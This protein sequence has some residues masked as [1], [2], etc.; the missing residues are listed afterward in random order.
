M[1]LETDTAADEAILYSCP[2][3]HEDIAVESHL[4]GET[5]RCPKCSHVFVPT[6]PKADPR[7][8]ESQVGVDVP[9]ID[10]AA[11]DEAVIRTVHPAMFRRNPFWFLLELTMLVGGIIVA[12]FAIFWS[13]DKTNDAYLSGAVNIIALGVALVGGVLLLSWYIRTRMVTLTISTKRTSLREGIFS[14]QTTEVQHDDIRNLQIDQSFLQRILNVGDIAI[15]SSG[16]DGL[17]VVAVGIPDPNGLAEIVR[18]RQ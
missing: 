1:T 18:Q 9:V 8:D 14:K 5:V 10:R 3:C 12:G 6:A 15:S 2:T 7:L 11:D 17:E 13:T 16:Q 4:F